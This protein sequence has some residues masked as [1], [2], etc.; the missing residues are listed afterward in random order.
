MDQ[1][2][3]T[4]VRDTR[5]WVE[6]AVIGLNLC[7]FAKAVHVKGQAHYVASIASDAQEALRDLAVQADE[8]LALSPEQRDTTLLVLPAWDCDFLTFNDA[9]AQGEKLLRKRGLEGILQLA[10]FHP[11]FQFEG[12]E[13]DDITNATNRSPWPVFHLL[14]EESLDRAVEA[15]PEAERIYEANMATMERLGEEGLRALDVGRS[16]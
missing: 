14:R 3:E 11:K 13:E 10:F 12:T 15:F 9:V 7:P 8:L 2:L 1:L 4:A 5:R 6:R 16:A